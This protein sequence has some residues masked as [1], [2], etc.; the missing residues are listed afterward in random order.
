MVAETKG[1]LLTTDQLMEVGVPEEVIS[2]LTENKWEAR[3]LKPGMGT[4]WT[5]LRTPP[6]EERVPLQVDIR[7]WTFLETDVVFKKDFGLY[8]QTPADLSTWVSLDVRFFELRLAQMDDHNPLPNPEVT[9]SISEPITTPRGN[10]RWLQIKRL[11]ED[12]TWGLKQRTI[13]VNP[14]G[15]EW[16]DTKPYNNRFW[17][18]W[19]N[20]I[21]RYTP[22][23]DD[24]TI[25]WRSKHKPI[26]G[27]E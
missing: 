2:W 14:S 3:E 15:V 13:L 21:N 8:L 27:M 9:L 7:S 4:K 1:A 25:F 20:T 23:W 12:V 22:R 24:P 6:N 11:N 5:I 18:A 16:Q 10:E 19:E 17:K 26:P